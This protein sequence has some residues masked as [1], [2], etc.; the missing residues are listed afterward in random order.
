MCLLGWES[1][2]MC[3]SWSITTTT[4]FR[5]LSQVPTHRSPQRQNRFPPS[6]T[7]LEATRA[8]SGLPLE[9]LQCEFWVPGS[10]VR[11]DSA[12][13][14]GKE[15]FKEILSTS[16]ETCRTWIER[17]TQDH[18]FKEGLTVSTTINTSDKVCCAVVMYISVWAFNS[19]QDFCRRV[20]PDDSNK[21]KDT[22]VEVAVY[23]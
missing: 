19:T 10:S 11:A 23:F 6:Q 12:K 16:Q 22:G 9:H 17:S 7:V 5:T 20:N 21:T 8:A 14:S 3:R 15:L 18:P 1:M 4:S 2:M 13:F